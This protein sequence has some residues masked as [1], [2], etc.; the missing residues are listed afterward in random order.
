MPLGAVVRGANAQDGRQTRHLLRSLVVRLPAAGPDRRSW[1]TAQGDGAYGDRPSRKRA[2]RARFRLRAPKRKERLRS[3]AR[4][5]GTVE[6][7]HNFFAQFGR[8]VRRL[9]RSAQRYLGW[10][11]LA[12]CII[13]IR[14]G[15]VP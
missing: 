11:Q 8:I 13:F 3:L 14:A 9:D 12:A 15:F 6:R 1:P 7:C 10:V 5:R 2:L 4:V